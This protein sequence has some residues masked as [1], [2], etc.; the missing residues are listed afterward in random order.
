MNLLETAAITPHLAIKSLLALAN[1]EAD[2]EP[3][4][5]EPAPSHPRREKS[6]I[7]PTPRLVALKAKRPRAGGSY[8]WS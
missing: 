7:R 6:A 4:I 1:R 2:L 8:L 5:A 3:M